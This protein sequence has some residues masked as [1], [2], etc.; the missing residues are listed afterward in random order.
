MSIAPTPTCAVASTKTDPRNYTVAGGATAVD[1][2]RSEAKE[3]KGRKWRK[4]KNA[5]FKDRYR[6]S[7]LRIPYGRIRDKKRPKRENRRSY[8]HFLS[9]WQWIGTAQL[10]SFDR[11]GRCHSSY[12]EP[13]RWAR[14]NA[15][16]PN[17]LQNLHVY[18]EFSISI[19]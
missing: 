6:R 2:R 4:G 16:H 17:V 5:H 14:R 19:S 7:I 8:I 15:M 10:L 9:S 12:C 11:R 1:C 13:W 18:S 3:R